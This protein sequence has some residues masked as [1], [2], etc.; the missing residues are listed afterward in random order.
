MQI[1]VGWTIENAVLFWPVNAI[2][3]KVLVI[4]GVRSTGIDVDWPYRL[5]GP[6]DTVKPS[7]F[8]ISDEDVE[9]I[10]PEGAG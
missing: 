3:V 7:S 2:P 1:K 5:V 9:T 6:P 8:I 10:V 4:V